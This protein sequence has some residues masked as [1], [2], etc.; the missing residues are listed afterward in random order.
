MNLVALTDRP[1]V[2]HFRS[3]SAP[4]LE[5][6]RATSAI[7]IM[8]RAALLARPIFRASTKLTN[9]HC[10][11]RFISGNDPLRISA[12]SEERS[13]ALSQLRDL[14]RP[15]KV[16]GIVMTASADSRGWVKPFKTGVSSRRGLAQPKQRSEAAPDYSASANAGDRHLRT[17][18]I[19]GAR[20]ALG[21]FETSR[22]PEACG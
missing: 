1:A 5:C 9:T 22:I 12:I 13:R 14:Q 2:P 11:F 6:E 21:G 10:R 18:L 20:A 8:R 19:H 3:G 17:L 15:G 7:V 4:D 16:E